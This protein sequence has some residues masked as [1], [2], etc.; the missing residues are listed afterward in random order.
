MKVLKLI[1]VGSFGAVARMS[2]AMRAGF[3]VRQNA[4]SP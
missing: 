3:I 1:F 2:R 4:A